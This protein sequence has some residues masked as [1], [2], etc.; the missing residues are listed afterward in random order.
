MNQ[1]I[2][3]DIPFY[4]CSRCAECPEFL[5]EHCRNEC[6]TY[7]YMLSWNYFILSI[8]FRFFRKLSKPDLK[9]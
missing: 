7:P 3:D 9:D 2:N 8:G 4:D 1:N 6:K 5:S